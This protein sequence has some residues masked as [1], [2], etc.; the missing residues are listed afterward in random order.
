MVTL[1]ELKKKKVFLRN[2]MDNEKI[3]LGRID[4]DTFDSYMEV[5]KQLTAVEEKL[6]KPLGK[7]GGS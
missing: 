5:V 7:K 2:K 4:G 6:L 3:V 1:L